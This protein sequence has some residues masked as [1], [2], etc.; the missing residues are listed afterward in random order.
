[1]TLLHMRECLLFLGQRIG[2]VARKYKPRGVI[3]IVVLLHDQ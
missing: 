1:V 3:N 2:N